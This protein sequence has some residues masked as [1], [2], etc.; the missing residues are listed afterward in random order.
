MSFCKIAQYSEL[1]FISRNPYICLF[2]E[3]F[4]RDFR[5]RALGAKMAEI[6]MK[7]GYALIFFSSCFS[8]GICQ[9]SYLIQTYYLELSPMELGK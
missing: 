7:L 2:Q 6:E 3:V 1:S 9:N 4:F 8:R 5:D